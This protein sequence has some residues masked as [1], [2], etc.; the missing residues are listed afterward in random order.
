MILKVQKRD[1]RI[2]RFDKSLISKAIYKAMCEV[3]AIEEKIAND[4]ASNIE[5]HTD[6]EHLS[7]NEIQILVENELMKSDMPDVARAYIIYRN[8]RDKARNSKSNQIIADIIAAKKMT[9]P[10]KM[11]T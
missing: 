1:G 3:G 10:V 11:R 7:V 5:K 6:K 9:L 4:I 8:K 2:V